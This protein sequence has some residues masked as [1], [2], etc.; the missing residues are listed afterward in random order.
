MARKIDKFELSD[1]DKIQ[2]ESIC[3]KGTQS[4]RVITRAM[5]LLQ[6]AHG[7]SVELVSQRL[8]R[9]RGATY[10]LRRTY[11]KQG[12]D[13]AL[14]DKA[15]SGRPTTISSIDE[16][17]I[18]ALACSEAPEGYAEWT[19]RLLADKAIELELVDKGS[20]AKSSVERILKKAKS[21]RTWRK[22]GV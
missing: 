22:C 19:I 10:N 9:S 6:L 20:I 4:A 1:S 12:L 11:L 17:R 13:Q 21:N 18:T 2:L 8:N 16:S 3:Q 5:T 15:R 7:D 14:Y